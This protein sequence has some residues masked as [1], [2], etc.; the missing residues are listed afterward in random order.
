MR[1]RNIDAPILPE[2]K[3]NMNNY[4]LKEK[5]RTVVAMH[6][7][8]GQIHTTNTPNFPTRK[9]KQPGGV[10][11]LLRGNHMTRFAG[12]ENDPAGRWTVSRF[13]GRKN[14]LKM[15]SLY[16]VCVGSKKSGDT[17]AWIQQYNHFRKRH[18][19][20]VDPRKQVVKDIA[21]HLEKDIASGDEII[22]C[23]DFMRILKERTAFTKN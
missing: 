16:R 6:C 8:Q 15:Y 12:S 3:L 14:Q 2:T 17:T 19:K 10:A 7:E 21:Q 5:M 11:T 13:Y 18:N 4:A 22:L 23:G 20:V 1:K 9:E